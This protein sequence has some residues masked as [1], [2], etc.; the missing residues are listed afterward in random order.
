MCHYTALM[1]NLYRSLVFIKHACWVLPYNDVCLP[2]QQRNKHLNIPTLFLLLVSNTLSKTKVKKGKEEKWK[3]VTL[4]GSYNNF[5]SICCFLLPG[6]LMTVAIFQSANVLETKY[7]C[8]VVSYS[9]LWTFPPLMFFPPF[10]MDTV[11]DG[12]CTEIVTDGAGTEF[13]FCNS[14]Y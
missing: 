8:F 10:V 14:E 4:S 3:A 9:C 2:L 13:R 1:L 5:V 12:A 11:T 7:T 6:P